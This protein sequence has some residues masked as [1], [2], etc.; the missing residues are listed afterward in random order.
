MRSILGSYGIVTLLHQSYTEFEGD[1][2][3]SVTDG[4]K[5]SVSGWSGTHLRKLSNIFLNMSGLP[6][7]FLISV[8]NIFI[9]LTP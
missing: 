5:L 6:L 1:P 9:N 4:I 3:K 8:G 7:K 2:L